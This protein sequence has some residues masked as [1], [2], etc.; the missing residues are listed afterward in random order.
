MKRLVNRK[1]V[2]PVIATILLIVVTVVVA[3]ILG[4]FVFTQSQKVESKPSAAIMAK[5]QPNSNDKI[6]MKHNG[7]DALDWADLRI[8]CTLG[9]DSATVYEDPTGGGQNILAAAADSSD[10]YVA[11]ETV[12]IDSVSG[13]DSLTEDE[14]YHVVL[15]HEPTGVVL[16]DA[17]VLVTSA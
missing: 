9:A 8:S 10:E 12:V 2:S 4:V 13:G 15:R 17:N 7:G 16:L 3:G 11:G 6:V 5:D 14:V 1:G